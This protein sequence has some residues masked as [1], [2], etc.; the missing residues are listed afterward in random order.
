MKN[1]IKILSFSGAPLWGVFLLT[2][3]GIV[4]GMTGFLF[5]YLINRVTKLFINGGIDIYDVTYASAFAACIFLFFVTRIFLSNKVIKLS[6]SVFWN[7]RKRIVELLSKSKYYETQ[8]LKDQIYAVIHHDAKNLLEATT[9]FIAVFTSIIMVVTCLVYMAFFSLILFGFSIVTLIVGIV[10]YQFVISRCDAHFVRSR[11]IE[12]NFLKSFDAIFFGLKEINLSPEKGVAIY[13]EKVSPLLTEGYERNRKAYTGYMN[14]QMVGLIGFYVLIT[15][16][17]LHLGFIFSLETS[18]IVNFT[19][20]LLFI[21]GPIEFVM[22][23]LPILSRANISLTKMVEVIDQLNAKVEDTN[24]TVEK[25]QRFSKIKVSDVMYEY[26]NAEGFHLGPVNFEI[27]PAETIFIYGG[28]GSGKS[29]FIKILLQLLDQKEGQIVLDGV[30]INEENKE[31]YTSLFAAVFSDFYLFDGV[32]GVENISEA[33][34]QEYLELFE[35]DKK[36]TIENG[37]FS[38]TN[39]STGQ[40]KRLAIIAALL[41]NKPILVLDEWAADQDPEFR[42]KFYKNIIPYLK[43]KG[44]TIVAITHDDAYYSASDRIYKMEYGKIVEKKTLLRS[45]ATA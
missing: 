26:K 20:L 17:L 42:K 33:Q 19:F 8:E 43:N 1:I 27:N 24:T 36:I 37:K 30:E 7:I 9:I 23:S 41:E 14:S 32:Y 22:G 38:T 18:I 40:R 5:I 15:F 10:I 44:I 28:N 35:V 29:T 13:N 12:S 25:R 39:L 11:E 21:L 34:V 3:V 45:L 6:Q 16:I 31:S 4:S 2:I